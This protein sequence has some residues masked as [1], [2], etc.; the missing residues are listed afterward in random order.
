MAVQKATRPN[1]KMPKGLE[2]ED[3]RLGAGDPARRG[4]MVNFRLEIRLNRGELIDE[5]ERGLILGTRRSFH[6]LERGIEG[7][8]VG[9]LRQLRVPPHL[10]YDDGRLLVCTG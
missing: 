10:A 8:Q 3:L 4:N 9:G 6:G 7:M 2:Y 5:G 1:G